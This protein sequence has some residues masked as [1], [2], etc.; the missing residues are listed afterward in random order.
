LEYEFNR[1]DNAWWQSL[2]ALDSKK[3]ELKKLQIEISFLEEDVKKYED[4]KNYFNKLLT[5]LNENEENK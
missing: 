2:N 1:A 4:E 3:E 5:E